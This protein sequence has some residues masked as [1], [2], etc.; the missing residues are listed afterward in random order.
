MRSLSFKIVAWFAGLLLISFMASLAVT[1]LVATRDGR[2][3]HLITAM[4][5]LQ[6]DTAV[7]ALESGGK[8]ALAAHL[9]RLDSS[10]AGRHHLADASGKDLL[11][12][13]SYEVKQM[14][15]MPPLPP[16]LI[17]KPPRSLQARSSDGRYL[18]V[19]EGNIGGFEPPNVFPYL[20]AVVAVVL[21]IC[22][23]L[24]LNLVRPLID[25]RKAVASFGKGDLSVRIGSTRRDEFGDVGRAFDAMADRIQT[26]LNAERRLLQDISHELNSPLARL[27][28]AVELARTAT[29][30]EA[31]LDR[32]KKEAVRIS[33]MVQELIQMTRVE[34]DP[35]TRATEDL[36]LAELLKGVCDDC[37][38]EADAKQ[39]RV[40]C[41]IDDEITIQADSVLLRRGIENVVRNAVK[42]APEAST[43]ELKARRTNDM[44]E[45]SVRDYGPG[46]PPQHLQEIFRP[47]FRVHNDRS[48]SSS[49][50]GL[51]LAIAHRVVHLHH[52]QI[53]AQNAE[54][55]LRVVIRLPAT[56]KNS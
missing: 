49:E 52:G 36:Q 14:P 40:H 5:R 33:E 7:A 22:Y 50:V 38:I 3:E 27:T 17:A 23:G 15:T 18:M 43:V 28:F 47:F 25:L 42:Y 4:V 8:E 19:L 9:R 29:D 10:F 2:R 32:A 53:E 55:G 34:A 16:F 39:C 1:A 31:A 37:L 12:G 24:T 56:L 41:E 51:G 11:S 54:P 26:L 48:R 30:R 20:F 44:A 21:L 35:E 6:A 46:V 45:I 13:V